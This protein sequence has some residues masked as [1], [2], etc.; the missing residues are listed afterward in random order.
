[1]IKYYRGVTQLELIVTITLM[2]IMSTT[3]MG[4]MSDVFRSYLW[5][6]Q[7]S[8]LTSDLD[9]ALQLIE[10]DLHGSVPFSAR[11]SSDK[12]TL[13]ML[14]IDN[15]F[16]VQKKPDGILD[17]SVN[18]VTY[19]WDSDLNQNLASSGDLFVMGHAP[20]YAGAAGVLNFDCPMPSYNAYV[21]LSGY[22]NPAC[23]AIVP[24]QANQIKPIAT[25]AATNAVKVGSAG[26]NTVTFNF[27]KTITNNIFNGPNPGLPQ[28]SSAVFLYATYP[29]MY[30]CESDNTL[31][32][33]SRYKLSSSVSNPN[34]IEGSG[35][36]VLDNIT[37]NGCKFSVDG[38][39]S[40]FVDILLQAQT[41]TNAIDLATRVH[42][43]RIQ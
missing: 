9:S 3:L 4:L 22:S 31:R 37:P 25:L 10:S 34:P 41:N 42:V 11:N 20:S 14:F 6:M 5:T 39:A 33:Y 2:G 12:R 21:P 43:D 8:A 15:A 26:T 19:Q 36:I 38:V 24:S 16:V 35:D 18:M 32:R 30:R 40:K 27:E 29:V 17:F 28:L 7:N 13:E 23:P 1:M